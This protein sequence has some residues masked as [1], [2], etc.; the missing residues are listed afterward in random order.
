MYCFWSS[1]ST[2]TVCCLVVSSL[3]L[4]RA[5]ERR[6][7]IA[8]ITSACCASTAWP[9]FCVQSS[10]W[11]IMS[12]TLGTWINDFTLSSQLCLA[13]TA[14]SASPLRVLLDLTQR[15]ACTTSSG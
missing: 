7:W 10:C 3:P 9:S 4:A 1:V 15:S 2:E 12:S 14:V 13:S 11:L 6:R 5:R 8:S